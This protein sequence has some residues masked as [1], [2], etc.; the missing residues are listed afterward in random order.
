MELGKVFAITVGD[1]DL[2]ELAQEG[3]EL[4]SLE[5]TP[6][7]NRTSLL[8]ALRIATVD[9]FQG[10]EANVVIVSF[11]R[12]NAERKAGFLRTSNHINVLC[13][14]AKHGMYIIGNSETA[15]GVNMFSEIITL[16]KTNDNF[17]DHLELCCPR[18]PTKVMEVKEVDDFAK[19]SPEGGC[20]E[21][22]DDR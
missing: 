22:C 12:S 1:R 4:E 19:L 7:A 3:I 16:L 15:E 20:N 18:H 14:R 10:E 2:D 13:S 11:V 5:P 6:V 17:G 9:N 8:K 21:Q